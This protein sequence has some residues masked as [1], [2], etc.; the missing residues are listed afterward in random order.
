MIIYRALIRSKI[1]YACQA[2]DTAS[3][4]AKKELD[5]LQAAAL[6]IA[7]GA[8]KST[9]ISS[10]Q[11]ECGEMPLELRRQNFCLKYAAKIN[12]SENNPTSDILQETWQQQYMKDNQR[13]FL[14]STRPYLEQITEGSA[15]ERISGIPPWHLTPPEVD[16]STHDL[17]KKKESSDLVMRALAI[18]NMSNTDEDALQIFTDGLKDGRGRVGAAFYAPQRNHEESYRLT[19]HAAT[20]TAELIA[21]RQALQYLKTEKTKSVVIYSDSL[22]A[23][24]ALERR[25]S[26]SRPNLIREVLELNHDINTAGTTIR[27]HWIPSHVGLKGNERANSLAKEALDQPAVQINISKERLEMY[28]QIDDISRTRWQKQW[29]E[30]FV[31]RHYYAIQREVGKETRLSERMNRREETITTRLRLGRCRLNYYLHAMRCHPDGTCDACGQQETIRHLLM[32][33]QSHSTLH[34]RLNEGNLQ[35]PKELHEILRDERTIKIIVN[36]VMENKELTGR[37]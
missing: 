2:Y 9:A 28:N 19:D 10:L 29:D 36:Y 8:M 25:E 22:C 1:D 4:T 34:F 26:K 20:Y 15:K 37:I 12:C 30:G 3:D 27:F 32:E 16:T 24:Q 14:K 21:I 18:E 17:F 11:V 33:C 31:G 23:L 13:S 5:K 6:R 35:Q 7:C